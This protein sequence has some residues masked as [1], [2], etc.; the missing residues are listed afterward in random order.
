MRATA[1]TPATALPRAS[2]GGSAGG[3]RW[4]L[5]GLTI[6]APFALLA[7][8]EGA[9]RA[10]GV[11]GTTPLFVPVADAPQYLH[12]H[13]RA[14]ERL[15]PAGEAPSLWIHP[16]PFLRDKAPGTLRLFVQGGSTAAGYPYGH[17]ASLAGLLDQR[18]QRTYPDLDVEVVSTAVSAVNSYALLDFS[19]EILEQRPDGVLIYAGHN[20]YLG[21]LGVGSGYSPGRRR[22]VVLA[23]L[24]TRDVR[25][26]QL[27][28]RGW[29]ALTSEARASGGAGGGA[30]RTL[31]ARIV[32]EKHIPLGSPLYHRGVEQLRANLRALLARYRRAGVPVW[33]G[34]VASNLRHQ[35]PFVAGHG[36]G[37][38]GADR[39]AWRR[40]FASGDL[41]LAQ[42]DAAAALVAF[43]RAVEIDDLHASGHFGRGLALEE[44]S[45]FAE[46]R[47]AYAA[48][49]DRDELR[50]RAPSEVN[51]VIRRVAA[52][53]GARVVEVEAALEAAAPHGLI[54]DEL[55]L[56]HLHPNLEG[57][58]LL[59]DAFYRALMTEGPR[60]IGPESG[61]ESG[62]G[63]RSV[64]GPGSGAEPVP[65]A[66]AL[67][68]AR[69]EM[70]VTEVDRLYGEWRIGRLT[71]DWP[72]T[73]EPRPYRPPRPE[74]AVERIADGYRRGA[75]DWPE[76]M[77]RLLDHHRRTGATA[78]AARVA[79]LLAEAF[80]H[81][82]E[83]QR[84]AARLLAAAGRP[85]AA[86]Y[87]RRAA[88]PSER[89]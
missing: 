75:L 79:A 28:R 63:S 30:G 4:L 76:A 52:E 17:G 40:S 31:M 72:F 34:T 46:A 74:G 51:R 7:V 24:A 20:E 86:V 53:E 83:D 27:A 56:E 69:R 10:A 33:I 42:G 18:L 25:L 67:R 14:V 82:A 41:A 29:A 13:R 77:R 35:A 71:S 8:A 65:R 68:Q 66:V 78:E 64:R 55:M 49:R 16:V 73:D 12:A 47:R 59:A 50:F 80:P 19:G 44:L 39:A 5:A 9:L 1:I 88:R 43:E 70:P 26:M 54:G 85:D 21:L 3:R 15:L 58:L 11:G 38:T 37:A 32:G 60:G 87:R 2:L 61:P 6:L 84:T 57:Y 22:P 48:A 23:S 36:P 89:R 62:P 81:L 45:R